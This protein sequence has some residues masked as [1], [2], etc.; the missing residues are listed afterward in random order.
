MPNN[1]SIV[2]TPAMLRE[3][4]V[5]NLSVV[6]GHASPRAEKMHDRQPD[7]DDPDESRYDPRSH[8]SRVLKPAA[9][10]QLTCSSPRATKKEP[11]DHGSAHDQ[12]PGGRLDLANLLF[13]D[14]AG[15]LD[16]RE[17][18]VEDLVHR[19]Q[20]QV[21]PRRLSSTKRAA[22]PDT[23]SSERDD[24]SAGANG[25]LM[26]FGVVLRVNSTSQEPPSD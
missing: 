7:A 26:W 24:G 20:P 2:L 5:A 8:T 16:A 12:Q 13:D 17:D 19:R 25:R 14:D 3:P 6:R 21:Y 23:G 1:L 10:G 22:A 4:R 18:R 11:Q 15:R 9:Y